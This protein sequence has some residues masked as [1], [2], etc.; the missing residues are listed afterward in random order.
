M[1]KRWRQREV[2]IREK[3][4][5]PNSQ[6]DSKKPMSRKTPSRGG[7]QQPHQTLEKFKKY[8]GARSTTQW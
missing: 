3:K 1:F 6:Y 5:P 7:R 8:K 2:S 4:L